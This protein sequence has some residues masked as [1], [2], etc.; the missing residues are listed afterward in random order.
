MRRARNVS[1]GNSGSK[2]R[3]ARI[4]HGKVDQMCSP[5]TT[6]RGVTPRISGS[7]VAYVASR[8]WM[9]SSDTSSCARQYRINAQNT[10]RWSSQC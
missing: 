3:I 5:R 9:R 10:F 6:S 2:M 1:A 7:M 4:L 8:K